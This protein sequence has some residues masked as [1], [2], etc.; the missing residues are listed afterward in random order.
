MQL[1]TE[2]RVPLSLEKLAVI[3]LGSSRVKVPISKSVKLIPSPA[4]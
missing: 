1:E 3:S 2:L 4:S